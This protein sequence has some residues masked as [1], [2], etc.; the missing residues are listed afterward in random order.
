V[1]ESVVTI[2]NFAQ[3]IVEDYNISSSYHAII[4]KSIQDQLTDFKMHSGLYDLD[5]GELPEPGDEDLP[6]RGLL[7]G[8]DQGWWTGWRQ[9]LGQCGKGKGKQK[10][11]GRLKKRL[12]AVRDESVD[13]ADGDVE[14]WADGDD[15]DMEKPWQKER[16]LRIDEIEVI[17]STMHE[18]MRILIKVS[19]RLCAPLPWMLT[20]FVLVMSSS[21]SSSDL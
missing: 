13:G 3:T 21:T 7:E 11:K 10:S 18:D 16:P 19:S 12:K 6:R 20:R 4:V 1:T 15:V 14:D 17:E 9:R 2:E 8:D 5:G